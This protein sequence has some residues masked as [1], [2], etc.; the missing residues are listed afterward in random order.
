MELN[1][2]YQ[3]DCLEVLKT[4][5]D[6][7]VDMV[8]TSP[9]YYALR[10]YGMD[11]QLGLESDFKE[12]ISKL[13][14]IFD[15]VRRVLKN[16]GTCWVNI[17]DTFG[18]GSGSGVRNGKQA[19]NRGTQQNAGWQE[20]GRSAIKGFEKSLLQIPARFAIGMTDRGWILRNEIIWHKTNV[21]PQSVKDRFTMDFEKIFLFSKHKNYYFKTQYD[22]AKYDGRKQERM[23]GSSKYANAPLVP[24]H[25][26]HT[27][28][29]RGH[30]RWQMIDGKR[31]RNKRAVWSIPNKPFKGA[32]Y[33]TF[34][35]ALIKTPILAGSPEGG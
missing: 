35:P 31:V 3:G 8:I 11:G 22:D 34:P 15:E 9:P 24:G 26:P 23:R 27:F 12:Y 10:D 1:K 5:P 28:A 2:I 21:M 6:E 13:C 29:A 18:T 25:A 30:E 33:A 7:S 32:H 16:T 4:W 20:N 19:S 17:G 14:D